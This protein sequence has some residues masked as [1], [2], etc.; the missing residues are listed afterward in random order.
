MVQK[1]NPHATISYIVAYD[2]EIIYVIDRTRTAVSVTQGAEYTRRSGN[3]LWIGEPRSQGER[4]VELGGGISAKTTTKGIFQDVDVRLT[5]GGLV[6]NIDNDNPVTG[7]IGTLLQ[8][9]GATVTRVHHPVPKKKV[10]ISGPDYYIDVTLHNSIFKGGSFDQMILSVND[11]NV[12]V[13]SIQNISVEAHNNSTVEFGKF[14]DL[15]ANVSSGSRILVG[16]GENSTIIAAGGLVE[17]ASVKNL[18]ASASASAT[19]KVGDVGTLVASASTYSQINAK[20]AKN[21]LDSTSTSGG[22][23]NIG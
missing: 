1:I 20:S 10:I 6:V 22:S 12:K 9:C 2:A 8:K 11:S 13:E 21:V 17:I 18:N 23:V 16:A 4:I 15:R 7:L 14:T 5:N 3:T 19:V